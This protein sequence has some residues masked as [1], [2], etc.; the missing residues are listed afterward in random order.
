MY[1]LWV[2]S[3]DPG[4]LYT[5]FS[6]YHTAKEVGD[7]LIWDYEIKLSPGQIGWS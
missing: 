7:S 2:Y 4:W 3:D 1:R 6:H 5:T